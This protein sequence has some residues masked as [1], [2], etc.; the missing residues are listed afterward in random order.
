MSFEN[1]HDNSGK[2]QETIFAWREKYY[3]E[4][5]VDQ[6]LAEPII[7]TLDDMLD[8]G[9]SLW[10]HQVDYQP[11]FVQTTVEAST[12]EV[13]GGRMGA[14]LKTNVSLQHARYWNQSDSFDESYLLQIGAS[15]NHSGHGHNVYTTWLAIRRYPRYDSLSLLSSTALRWA[16]VGSDGQTSIH[17]AVNW[18][19]VVGYELEQ[20]G[21]DLNAFNHTLRAAR[22]HLYSGLYGGTSNEDR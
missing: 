7:A 9:S 10:D 12:I 2:L 6:A 5:G 20:I 18:T 1:T 3:T 22:S 4:D 14:F 21:A 19:G 17:E 16:V 11:G 13:L 15:D 8:D